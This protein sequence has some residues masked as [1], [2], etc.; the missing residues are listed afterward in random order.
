[1]HAGGGN[2]SAQVGGRT[3]A[4]QASASQLE[5]NSFCSSQHASS[6]GG[7]GGDTNDL[8]PRELSGVMGGLGNATA[9]C[10]GSAVHAFGSGSGRAPV[11]GGS[12]GGGGQGNAYGLLPDGSKPGASTAWA[13]RAMERIGSTVL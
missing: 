3:A 10:G 11:G 5:I 7:G 4:A 9:S 6:S 2:T 12:A 13:L 1:M 8:A